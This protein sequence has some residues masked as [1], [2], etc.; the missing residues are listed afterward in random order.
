MRKLWKRTLGTLT[1][2][3]L[4]C[5]MAAPVSAQVTF[6]QIRLGDVNGDSLVDA[7]DAVCTLKHYTRTVMGIDSNEVTDET[8][9]EDVTMDGVIDADDASAILSFYVKTLCGKKPLWADY[10]E[11]TYVDKLVYGGEL[12]LKDLYLE[13]G[14]A[15]GKPG[16]DVTVPIYLAG[17]K[18]LCGFQFFQPAP[19]GLDL[20]DIKVNPLDSEDPVV[21]NPADNVGCAIWITHDVKHNVMMHDGYV[22]MEYTFHIPEDTESGTIFELKGS[23]D[24]KM[25]NKF[26]DKN[27]GAYQ[28]TFVTGIVAVK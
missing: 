20:V 9:S 10:R 14:C 27:L 4:G 25:Y 18:P 19:E 7:A 13:I 28:Y 26:C 12:N 5:G 24:P 2:A 21:V 17:E 15:E 8:I 22:I 23:S 11:T 16:D 1:A 6:T 3:A